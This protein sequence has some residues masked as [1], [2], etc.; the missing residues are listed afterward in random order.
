MDKRA[1]EQ[2]RREGTLLHLEGGVE[3]PQPGGLGVKMILT[4]MTGSRMVG[5]TAGFHQPGQSFEPHVHPV[6]E[7]ILIVMKG[8]GQMFLKDRW[9]DVQ[10]GDIVYAPEG[11][12]HGT[13]NPEGNEGIFITI[14]C[15]GPPQYDLYYKSGYLKEKDQDDD[16]EENAK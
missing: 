7:E 3:Y 15:A 14:G 12:P 8:K 10:E 5:I 9:L 2:V 11:V 6:S 16:R 13:R 4:P 1:A